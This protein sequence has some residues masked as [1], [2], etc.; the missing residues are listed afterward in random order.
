M[1]GAVLHSP[2]HYGKQVKRLA[3]M[4]KNDDNQKSSAE[5]L[6]IPAHE[7]EGGD[8]ARFIMF[9]QPQGRRFEECLPVRAAAHPSVEL[10]RYSLVVFHE[11]LAVEL[12]ESHHAHVRVRAADLWAP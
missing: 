11:L 9:L 10:L 8:V 6:Q 3:D 7:R 1:S 2:T 4:R 12:G 5:Q